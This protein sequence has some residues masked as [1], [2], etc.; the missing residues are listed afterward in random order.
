MGERQR[1]LGS[2]SSR[3][4]CAQIKKSHAATIEA[5]ADTAGGTVQTKVQIAFTILVTVKLAFEINFEIEVE[6]EIAIQVQIEQQVSIE[7][8]IQSEID[9]SAEIEKSGTWIEIAGIAQF[10]QISVAR[11][12]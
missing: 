8:K 12:R 9:L 5:L 10:L 7:P 11:K 6:N 1:C 4:S 3:A 2:G